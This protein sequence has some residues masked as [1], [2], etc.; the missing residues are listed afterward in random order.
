MK[1]VIRWLENRIERLERTYADARELEAGGDSGEVYR[2]LDGTI[3]EAR[4]ALEALR[5]ADAP[6]SKKKRATTPPPADAPKRKRG[7]P[8]KADAAARTI[9]LVDPEAFAA[10]GGDTIPPPPPA[11]LNG[12]ASHGH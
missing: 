9:S 10:D 7:R 8:R 5:A 11:G 6:A 3:A 12:E 1:T 2:S 4:A